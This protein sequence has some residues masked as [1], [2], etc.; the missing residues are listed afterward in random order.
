MRLLEANDLLARSVAWRLRRAIDVLGRSKK[1]VVVTDC[2]ASHFRLATLL[3]DFEVP[4][5]ILIRRLPA[6]RQETTVIHFADAVYRGDT[7]RGLENDVG[8][9]DH[10]ITCLDLSPPTTARWP[11]PFTSLLRA[12]FDPE[13]VEAPSD[14]AYEVFECDAVTNVPEARPAS[15]RFRI[16]TSD[17]R[18]SFIESHPDLVRHG[19]QRAG[20]RT[21]TLTLPTRQ[22]LAYR[23]AVLKWLLETLGAA[24]DQFAGP[25][26]RPALVVFYRNDAE[27]SMIVPQLAT[28][29]GTAFDGVYGVPLP[30][31]ADGSREAFARATPQLLAGIRRVGSTNMFE[32]PP[33]RPYIALY[34]DDACVTGR[35]LFNFVVR[36]G[37]TMRSQRPFSVVV[38]PIVSRL[39]PA[40]EYFFTALCTHISP[41]HDSGSPNDAQIPMIFRPLFRL[42]VG[43]LVPAEAEPIN[44]FLTDLR[45][46]LANVDDRSR[47]YAENIL[48]RAEHVFRGDALSINDTPVVT[49]AL[50]GGEQ[51]VSRLT[52]AAIRIRQ[53]LSLHEQNIGVLGEL[54]HEFFVAFEN[55]DHAV[56]A[57]LALEPRLLNLPP[58]R[59]QCWRGITELALSAIADGMSDA[60]KSDGL[61]VLASQGVLV[62]VLDRV[63]PFVGGSRHL[64]DQLV[65][66]LYEMAASPQV[67]R[68][69]LVST[70]TSSWA[71]D[72]RRYVRRAV[73]SIERL[74]VAREIV[75]VD[76]A[77][78]E[79]MSLISR[80]MF[81]APPQKR[82]ANLTDWIARDTERR[83]AT[84]GDEVRILLNGAIRVVDMV[85]RPALDVFEWLARYKGD[86]DIVR[87]IR[88][89]RPLLIQAVT[90]LLEFTSIRGQRPIG[91]TRAGEIV[92]LWENIG[93]HSLTRGA[94]VIIGD[95]DRADAGGVTSTGVLIE[96]ILPRYVC[97]PTKLLVCL[98]KSRLHGVQL[99]AAA[100]EARRRAIA[101]VPCPLK[102]L[103]EAFDLVIG[104]MVKHGA[105][106][107][108]AVSA[109]FDGSALQV[110]FTDTTR[111]KDKVGS[112]RSQ[113]AVEALASTAGFL[114]RFDIPTKPG[115]VYASVIEFPQTFVIE[116]DLLS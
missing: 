60:E 76:E 115:E 77:W 100:D 55:N 27:V 57:I 103:A 26:Y 64:V 70:L 106:G 20:G 86:I 14:G 39:S 79:V 10:T 88:D 83:T 1:I 98:M 45:L 107:S 66:S 8:Q 19:L 65:V 56:L 51:P 105:P 84:P 7:L 116:V 111:Q 6:S 110:R 17:E 31:I 24:A 73:A 89:E 109:A 112:K 41:E 95:C 4:I 54:L 12:Q 52:Y 37:R 92:R 34:I 35:T 22:V 49:H 68:A 97:W 46:L 3:R 101:V 32:P 74:N 78:Q 30:F 11:T 42:Q 21:H 102:D 59:N 62:R 82:L 47:A 96:D 75:S 85:F 69:R 72:D 9:P 71:D 99:N 13:E 58:L 91:A 5:D 38:I 18:Q 113:A 43:S 81:H 114:V 23:E 29:L 108:H 50:Y 48:H 93:R 104:D 53:L 15:E 67:P 16:G 80:T 2:E 36:A 61:A 90:E 28:Q 40:E 44:H 63:L 94:E 33:E 25:P 87:R